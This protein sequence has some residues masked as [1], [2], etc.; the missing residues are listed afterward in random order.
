MI[1]NGAWSAAV[2]SPDVQDVLKAHSV[3]ISWVR[4]SAA[5]EDKMKEATSG[6]EP[7][8]SFLYE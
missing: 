3:N 4:E 2:S 1:V 6:L 8:T 5:N 7:L